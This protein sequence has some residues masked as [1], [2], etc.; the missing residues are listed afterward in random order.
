MKMPRGLSIVVMARIK[1]ALRDLTV[2]I[3]DFYIQQLVDNYNMTL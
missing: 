3:D 1:D 2:K